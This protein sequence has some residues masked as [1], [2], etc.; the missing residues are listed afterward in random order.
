MKSE[1]NSISVK[2]FLHF[3]ELTKIE[4]NLKQTLFRG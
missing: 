1:I 2:S 3:R 4:D